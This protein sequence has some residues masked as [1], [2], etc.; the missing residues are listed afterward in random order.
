MKTKGYFFNPTQPEMKSHCHL[1]REHQPEKTSA[2]EVSLFY[3]FKI[4]RS[5][6]GTLPIIPDGCIDLLFCFNPSNTFAVIGTS[7]QHRCSYTFKN[8]SEYFGVRLLPEQSSFK[9]KCS[10]KELIQQQQIPLS[11]VLH[12]DHSLLE[13]LE[14]RSTFQER[15]TYFNSY[16]KSNLPEVDYERNLITYCLNKIYSTEGQL[17]I[18]EL[19]CETGYSDRY[20]RKK[21]ED[22]IGFS[23]KQFSQIVKLQHSVHKLLNHNLDLNDIIEEHGFYDTSHFYKGFKKYMEVT[24]EQYRYLFNHSFANIDQATISTISQNT[25]T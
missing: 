5:S 21:F 15:V 19:A 9:F 8:D 1:Y 3:Q 13:E 14:N 24:P 16:L 20:I 11:D 6:P 2:R 7:P 17:N 12:I 22:Y 23:P 10:T 25:K 4:D 18:K